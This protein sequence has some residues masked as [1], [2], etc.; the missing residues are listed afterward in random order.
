MFYVITEDRFMRQQQKRVQKARID[1]QNK[2]FDY[3]K[4]ISKCNICYT[5]CGWHCYE[6]E[7]DFCQDH[8]VQHKEKGL[9]KKVIQ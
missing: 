1:K 4:P 8:F 6:C 5:L 2:E 3:N 9:C 7:T